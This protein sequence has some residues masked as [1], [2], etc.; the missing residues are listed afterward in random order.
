MAVR[1]RNI[2]HVEKEIRDSRLG[3][4]LKIAIVG[5]RNFPHRE[6]IEDYIKNLD[7]DIIIVSG[8]ARGVDA[9]AEQTARQLGLKTE[10]YPADWKKYGKS[11]GYRRNIQIAEAL[12]RIVAF[13]DGKSKGT[14]HTIEIAKKQGK[15]VEIVG[16]EDQ[17]GLSEQKN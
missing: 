5:S 8:G 14:F 9:I 7:K 12:D 15:P 11:A 2:G 4:A 17:G 3:E 6:K 13:W 10:I 1:K 16:G